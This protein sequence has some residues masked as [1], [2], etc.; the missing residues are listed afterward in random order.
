MT[1]SK[2]DTYAFDGYKTHIVPQMQKFETETK[3]T[4]ESFVED[5]N[6][7]NDQIKY[8]QLD[9]RLKA[10]EAQMKRLC[11]DADAAL[12]NGLTDDD[13]YRGANS[14]YNQAKINGIKQQ[15]TQLN[16]YNN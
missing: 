1:S 8:Q 2:P 5:T 10:L 16:D 13:V 3:K 12:N 6:F 9:A 7:D 14:L 4:H 11:R 15:F